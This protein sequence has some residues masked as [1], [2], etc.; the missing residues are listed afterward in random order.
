[1]SETGSGN[2]YIEALNEAVRPLVTVIF[3]G[4][5]ALGWFHDK[6]SDDAFVGFVGMV[7]GFWFNQRQQEKAAA[8]T[9]AAVTAA[10][11]AEK[12]NG[13]PKPPLPVAP[14]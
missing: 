2:K 5:A 10:V 4:A 6:M 12:K 7:I 14:A 3:A 11:L 8:A 9:T 1:M 13:E